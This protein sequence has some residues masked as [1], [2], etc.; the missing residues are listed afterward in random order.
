MPCREFSRN[1]YLGVGSAQTVDDPYLILGY[2]VIRKDMQYQFILCGI[3]K[4]L[5]AAVG[6]VLLPSHSTLYNLEIPWQ[7]MSIADSST[8]PPRGWVSSG[9]WHSPPVT[10]LPSPLPKLRKGHQYGA[11]YFARKPH[12]RCNTKLHWSSAKNINKNSNKT[13]HTHACKYVRNYSKYIITI[14]VYVCICIFKSYNILYVYV[15]KIL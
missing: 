13:V 11:R 7:V 15:C 14:Y 5:S 1:R 12:K 6:H 3:S 9:G 8:R 2:P 4:G 10:A